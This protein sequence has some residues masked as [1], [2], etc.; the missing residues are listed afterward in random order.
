MT[1]AIAEALVA[2][3]TEVLEVAAFE[4]ADLAEP[5]AP[6]PDAVATSLKFHGPPSGAVRMWI[7]PAEARAFAVATLGCDDPEPAVVDDAVRELTN[8]IAGH[9]LGRAW[10]DVC[11]ALDGAELGAAGSVDA[12]AVHFTGE[13][14]RIAVGMEVTP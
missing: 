2:A 7:D 12:Y 6:P 13:H 1:P 14:G 11:I 5:T 9:V 3:V 10:P 4:L 8:M